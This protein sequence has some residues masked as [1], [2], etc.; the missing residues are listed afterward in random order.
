VKPSPVTVRLEEAFRECREQF[1]GFDQSE[2]LRGRGVGRYR[3]EDVAGVGLA[4]DVEAV[5][6]V[7]QFRLS[8][9]D[10]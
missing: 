7:E 8:I 10:G 3:R 9:R 4:R 2:R 6:I 1:A 5:G